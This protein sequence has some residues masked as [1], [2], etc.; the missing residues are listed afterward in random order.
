MKLEY[1]IIKQWLGNNVYEIPTLDLLG[2]W[3][4]IQTRRMGA[5]KHIISDMLSGDYLQIPLLCFVAGD[6]MLR[7]K[8]GCVSW[9][10]AKETRSVNT[11]HCVF[12]GGT[13]KTD[14]LRDNQRAYF[15][16]KQGAYC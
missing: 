2:V 1:P 10:A 3:S 4:P 9:L 11:L 6:G 5:Y 8:W 13:N 7:V 16:F 12:A 14:A 15:T